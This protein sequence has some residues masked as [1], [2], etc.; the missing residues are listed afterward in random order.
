M[1]LGTKCSFVAEEVSA[2]PRLDL[3][4]SSFSLMNCSLALAGSLG[5]LAAGGLI[6]GAGWKWTGVAMG[7]FCVTGVV[8]YMFATSE[9]R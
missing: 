3:Y 1:P 2:L 9:R 4:A 5:L 7:M 6:D 8:P